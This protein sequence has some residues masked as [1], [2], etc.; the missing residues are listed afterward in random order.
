M[1]KIFNSPNKI[2][3][4]NELELEDIAYLC[5]RGGWPRS[6]FMEKEIALEQAFDYFDA[7]INAD[8]SRVDEV[9]RNPERMKRIMLSLSRHK[10]VKQV[11]K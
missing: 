2:E 8:I 5:C 4:S 3:G 6:T 10:G 1:E 9:S 11:I 7:V